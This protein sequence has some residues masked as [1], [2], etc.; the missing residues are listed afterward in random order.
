MRKVFISIMFLLV[1]QNLLFSQ[2]NT[3]KKEIQNFINQDSYEELFIYNCEEILTTDE[4]V[5][6]FITAGFLDEHYVNNREITKIG[7]VKLS[8]AGKCIKKNLVDFSSIFQES[9]RKS[10]KWEK[11]LDASYRNFSMGWIISFDKIP[12]PVIIIEKISGM[13]VNLYFFIVKNDELILLHKL[14]DQF[15]SISKIDVT[16]GVVYLSSKK[17]C[18][19]WNNEKYIFERKKS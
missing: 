10:L 7:F 15:S 6:Y 17:D 3:I 9:E 16:K 18:L 11:N 13:S 4:V 8:L 14:N 2:N 5:I 19:F 1:L 12:E